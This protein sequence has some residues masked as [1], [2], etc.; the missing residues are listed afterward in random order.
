VGGEEFEGSTGKVIWTS[1][2]FGT[3]NQTG[4]GGKEWQRTGRSL[5]ARNIRGDLLA[6]CRPH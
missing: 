1:A 2:S 5:E 3:D 6:Y 4:R